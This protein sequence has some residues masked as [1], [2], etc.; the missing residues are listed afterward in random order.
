MKGSLKDGD[1]QHRVSF[2]IGASGAI[3]QAVF[4][5]LSAQGQRVGGTYHSRKEELLTFIAN[6][7][8]E[9]SLHCAVQCDTSNRQSVA[10]AYNKLVAELGEPDNLIYCAGIRRDKPQIFQTTE[11][12]DVVLNTNLR[13]AADFARL[14]LKS[15]TQAK[16]GCIVFISSVAGSYGLAGQSNYGASKAGMEAFVRSVSREVG[17]FG[18]SINAVAPGLIESEMTAD[19]PPAAT[20]NFLANIPFRR[21]GQPNEVAS[22]VAFLTTEQASYIT[23]QTFTVDGGLSA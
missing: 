17:Q 21:F 14:A 10:E 4:A 1:K 19:L 11:D 9:K 22:L 12:W 20:R 13:G 6:I 8:P 7:D 18:V 16:R 15:M 2:V 3:G 23:G 5:E